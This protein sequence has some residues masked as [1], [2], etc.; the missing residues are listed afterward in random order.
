MKILPKLFLLA[1]VIAFIVEDIL[2]VGHFTIIAT[3][4]GW[5]DLALVLAVFSIAIRVVFEPEEKRV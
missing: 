1:A 3:A 2:A 4:G 5:L